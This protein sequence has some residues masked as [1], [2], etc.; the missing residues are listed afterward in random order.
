MRLDEADQG[1]H[2]NFDFLRFLLATGVVFT[3]S[4]VLLRGPGQA[5]DALDR[6]TGGQVSGGTAVSFFFFISGFLV[7]ESWRRSRTGWAYFRKR[8][9]R[10]FPAFVV[11]SLFCAL[12]VGPLGAD[13]AGAYFHQFR[14][15]PFLVYMGLLVGPFLPP[16][17]LHLPLPNAV[18]GSFW[19]LRYEFWCYVLVALLG[20]TGLLA[21][22]AWIAALW[23]VVLAVVTLQNVGALR[24]PRPELHLLG[25]PS[26]WP[27]LL[28]FFVAGMTFRVFGDRVRLT[29]IG[30]FVSLAALAAVLALHAGACL[31]LPTLGAYLL[32][33]VAYSP[34]V[35]L[36]RWGKYGDFSYGLYLYGFPVQQL[37][38]QYAGRNLTPVSLFAAAMLLTTALAA[39][40]WHLVE[41]PF[42]RLGRDRVR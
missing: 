28:A 18:D 34:R 22:R 30:A 35:P 9:L 31:A 4:Y 7:T 42:L 20:A 40:S 13:S 39:L 1:R 26:L 27:G 8:L 19:T 41:K 25:S 10:I 38:I 6:W 16:V 17:F 23:A 2:N 37:L 12:V 32:L 36:Q 14:P 29:P 33:W 5:A 21:R 3:H 15:V 11:V 24:L